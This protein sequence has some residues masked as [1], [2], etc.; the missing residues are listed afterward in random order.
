MISPRAHPSSKLVPG[1]AARR[2]FTQLADAAG[3][4]LFD[5]NTVHSLDGRLYS[6]D[7]RCAAAITRTL[8]LA[9]SHAHVLTLTLTLT[10]LHSHTHAHIRSFNG[11]LVSTLD[12]TP[13]AASEGM[14]LGDTRDNLPTG[15]MLLAPGPCVVEGGATAASCTRPAAVELD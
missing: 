5:L 14:F 1:E 10:C 4:D 9:R 2:Q 12:G 8:T 3:T 15:F 11:A 7:Y 13:T 6:M